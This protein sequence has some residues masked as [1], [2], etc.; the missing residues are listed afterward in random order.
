[1]SG[2]SGKRLTG[3]HKPGILLVAPSSPSH[4]L[5]PVD[6]WP[7]L[8]AAFELSARELQIVQRVF[9]DQKEERIA[10]ELGISPHTV[11]TYFQR[12][13][14]KLHVASRPQLILRVVSE[15]LL[16]FPRHLDASTSAKGTIEMPDA[17]R[18]DQHL[19]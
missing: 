19:T 16:L 2:T 10:Y 1:M 9:Q 7:L 6:A 12:L 13:Y 11:N 15:F 14:A 5:L 17:V 8:R 4:P 3:R 18:P